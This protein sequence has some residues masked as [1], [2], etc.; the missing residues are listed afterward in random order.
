MSL[1]SSLNMYSL[2]KKIFSLLL[3]G[4]AVALILNLNI[5]GRGA[6]EWAVEFWHQPQVQKVYQGVRDRIVA[7]IHKDISV[8]DVFKSE[9]PNHE[10]NQ[11]S[12]SKPAGAAVEGKPTQT[13]V[14][15]LEKLNEEDRKALDKILEK[16]SK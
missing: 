8:E 11:P 13:K 3:V 1:Y 14:I 5:R 15:Q 4:M 6:R 9:L 2:L 12:D 10:G 16:A 7:V